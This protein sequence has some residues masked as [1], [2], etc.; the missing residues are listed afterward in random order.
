MKKITIGVV[1]VAII[2]ILGI[3]TYKNITARAASKSKSSQFSRSKASITDIK[4]TVSGS[5]SVLSAESDVIKS[6]Y[7][8]TVASVLVSKDQAVNAGDELVTFQNGSAPITAPYDGIISDVYISPGDSIN[9]DQQLLNM[10]DNKN[11]Y[12]VVSVD[13]TDLP[14]LKVGQKAD[15]KVNAFPDVKFTGTVKDISQQ[16]EY[17][18]GVSNFN[19][20]ISFDEIHDIKVGMSTEASIA[21]ASKENVLAV[22]IEAIKDSGDKK[23]VITS[24][25]KGKTKL[26]EVKTGISNGTMVE[27]V[28]GLTEGEQVQLPQTQSTA[29]NSSNTNGRNGFR[30]MGNTGSGKQAQGGRQSR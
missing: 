4:S 3:V 13:E 21:T 19:V 17:T 7:R 15:I 28:S 12:T 14:N 20:T 24:D 10:F 25:G 11:F 22:P 9:A 8:D 30:M 6:Q 27:I 26:K 18:N 1:V 2:G 23:Y 5:G 16:G 29:Q